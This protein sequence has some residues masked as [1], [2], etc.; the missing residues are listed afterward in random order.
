IFYYPTKDQVQVLEEVTK[1]GMDELQVPMPK[2]QADV[3]LSEVPPSL[4]K[5]GGVEVSESITEEIIQVPLRAKLYLE[6]K[7][8]WII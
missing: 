4:K 8:D 6:V 1:F 5:I 3:F 2:E 7:G